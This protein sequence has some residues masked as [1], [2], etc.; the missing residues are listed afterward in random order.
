MACRH[1]SPLCNI[2]P[3]SSMRLCKLRRKLVFDTK[4]NTIV[5]VLLPVDKYN[6]DFSNYQ[7][8]IQYVCYMKT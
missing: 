3:V 1:K 2:L 7:G 4:K 5:W 8:V 6:K